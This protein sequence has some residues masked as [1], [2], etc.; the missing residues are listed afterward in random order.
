MTLLPL[1]ANIGLRNQYDISAE[2]RSLNDEQTFPIDIPYTHRM[3]ARYHDAF[4]GAKR[5]P[6]LLKR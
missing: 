3:Y 6:Y 4:G 2:T 1:T 5:F